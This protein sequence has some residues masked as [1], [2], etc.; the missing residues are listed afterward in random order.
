EPARRFL[1][2]RHAFA[3]PSCREVIEDPVRLG[4]PVRAARALLAALLAEQTGVGE[5]CHPGLALR[6]AG[7]APGFEPGLRDGD[8]RLAHLLGAAPAVLDDPLE[9]VGRLPF[10]VDIG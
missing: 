7:R 8:R 9:E 10:P 1:E 5:I 6:G 2:G 4:A 3:P